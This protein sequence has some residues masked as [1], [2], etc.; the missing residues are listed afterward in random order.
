MELQL[1]GKCISIP[2]SQKERDRRI[3]NKCKYYQRDDLHENQDT[4]EKLEGKCNLGGTYE[5]F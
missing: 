3:I 2:S 5:G 1:L 4:F